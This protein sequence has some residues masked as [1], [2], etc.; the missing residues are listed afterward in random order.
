VRRIP[1]SLKVPIYIYIFFFFFQPLQLQASFV[2]TI[3]VL[4]LN[5]QFNSYSPESL[6]NILVN[7]FN[8]FSLYDMRIVWPI[9]CFEQALR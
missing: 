1:A 4:R 9:D 8:K 3:V 7:M 5:L 6:H 2:E